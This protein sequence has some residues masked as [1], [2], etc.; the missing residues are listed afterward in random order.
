M[1]IFVLRTA[2]DWEKANGAAVVIAESIDSVETL[3]Q[4]YEMEPDLRC[5]ESD[6]DARTDVEGP[7]RHVWVLVEAL[8]SVEK[9]ERVV[10]SSWDEA[11]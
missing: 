3:L 2:S 1:E 7:F 4:D 5:Y 11:P 9:V 6:N 8:P 10:V